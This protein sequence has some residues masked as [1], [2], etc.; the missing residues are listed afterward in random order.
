M[1]FKLG[2]LIPMAHYE[3]RV[4]KR[5]SIGELLLAQIRG[6]PDPRRKR[7]DAGGARLMQGGVAPAKRADAS[8]TMVDERVAAGAFAMQEIEIVSKEPK[9]ARSER[10]GDGT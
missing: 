8:K 3:C 9:E 2:A 10:L 5:N 4:V 7:G 6:G 1:Y